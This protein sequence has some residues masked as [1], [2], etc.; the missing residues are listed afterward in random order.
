LRLAVLA[1][2]P[3]QYYGPLFRRLAQRVDLTVLFAH[4]ATPQDQARAGF[5]TAFEWDVDITSGYEHRFLENVARRPGADQFGGC[6]TPSVGARLREGRFDALLVMGWHLKSYVQGLIAAKRLGLPVLVRGDSHLD[7]PRSSLKR[8]AK[9]LAYPHLLWLFDAALYV[10]QRSR[11]YYTYYGYP[12]R[13]LFFSPH[14]VDTERFATWGTPEARAELR[15]AFGIS[16]E[17]RVALFAGKLV[18]FKRPADVVRAIE[19]CRESG[20]R[21]DVMVAG[22]GELREGLQ[23]LASQCNVPLHFLGFCNQSR[24][25]AAYA[26]SDVLVLPSDGRE[27]WGLVANEA[28]ACGRP[29]IVSDAC[30]CAPDLAADGQVGRVFPTGN[31]RALAAAIEAMFENPPSPAAIAAVSRRHSLDAAVTGIIEALTFL[32]AGASRQAA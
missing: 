7:T 28:L 3:V 17:A 31:V 9:A 19:V 10:G 21:L 27:T 6:D 32:R 13:R 24:M 18:A 25:P 2:H 20:R 16:P 12:E 5:G 23:S 8:I 30:G 22:D 26:A 4:R 1:S 15:S 29:I 11:T 14:C